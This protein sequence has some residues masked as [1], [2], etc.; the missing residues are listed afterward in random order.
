MFSEMMA[1]HI[2][3]ANAARKW[4]NARGSFV[5]DTRVWMKRP[6]LE[7]TSPP[8]ELI[9]SANKIT[10][11]GPDGVRFV[12]AARVEGCNIIWR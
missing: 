10:E 3:M 2:S 9:G 8:P 7:I 4:L 5:T 12:W 1:E 11:C 6:T